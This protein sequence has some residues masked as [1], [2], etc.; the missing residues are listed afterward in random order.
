MFSRVYNDSQSV[1]HP[2]VGISRGIYC[3]IAINGF[4]AQLT[5]SDTCMLR[6]PRYPTIFLLFSMGK[7]YATSAPSAMVLSWQAGGT[8]R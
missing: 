3:I 6:S 8:R 1:E 7:L 4:A 2:R 5:F